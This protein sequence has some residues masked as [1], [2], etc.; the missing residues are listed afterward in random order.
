MAHDLNRQALQTYWA[1]LPQFQDLKI[2]AKVTFD[3][4]G[5]GTTVSAKILMRKD[6]VLWASFG[7]MGLFEGA[8][9]MIT[10][11]SFHLL[12]HMSK[13]Y[14]RRSIEQLATETGL[15]LSLSEL[16]HMLIGKP[17]YLPELYSLISTDSVMV[18]RGERDALINTVGI[19]EHMETYRSA[20]RSNLRTETGDFMYSDYKE[21]DSMRLPTFVQ[22]E[23]KLNGHL[24]KV[25]FDYTS[26]ST[27]AIRQ[28]AFNIP[29]SYERIE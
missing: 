8:R 7:F 29:K 26:I 12:D 9:L 21:V 14:T 2:K 1:N 18:I 5:K 10:E 17:A 23:L 11:D 24:M 13:A 20:F 28:F 6:S 15:D 4:E 16:Q 27:D 3:E 25:E 22:S 19:N